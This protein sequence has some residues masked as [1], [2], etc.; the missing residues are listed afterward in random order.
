MPADPTLTRKITLGDRH[1]S[2][3]FS[4]KALR[5]AQK[6]FD[7]R[8]A[9]SLF[10]AMDPDV[11]IGLAFAAASINDASITPDV[12][13]KL[14]ESELAPLT[15]IPTPLVIAGK[16]MS[17]K[18]DLRA[19]R[20][21]Q[22]RFEMRPASSVVADLD[23]AVVCELAAAGSFHADE[24][25]NPESIEE[26]IDASPHHYDAVRDAV[27]AALRQGYERLRAPSKFAELQRVV[28]D[29]CVA[30]YARLNPPKEAA[31]PAGEAV[32]P[33]TVTAAGGPTSEPS[34][35]QGPVSG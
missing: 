6:H 11:T 31:Q 1:L 27:I 30:G 34:S 10:N 23:A 15:P 4:F 21:V 24:R 7:G 13:E 22:R 33:S 3:A 20:I 25:A 2:I 26:A 9:R 19:L 16:P 29:A 8:P 14:L 18:F 32:P 35:T 28:L 12:I 5:I 17:L